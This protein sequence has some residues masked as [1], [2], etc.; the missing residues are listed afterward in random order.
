MRPD[1]KE[2]KARID[3]VEY[4]VSLGVEL[5]PVGAGGEYR[6]LCPLPGHDE[7]APSFQVNRRKGLWHCFGCGAGGDVISFVMKREGVGFQ[8][9]L[10]ILTGPAGL[11]EP[12]RSE[13]ADRGCIFCA[14]ADYWSKCLGGSPSARSYLE[15]RGIG[16]P[17]IIGRYGIGFA[18]GRTR[19]RDWLLTK[20]FALDEIESAGLV[21]RRG[22]DSFFGRVTFPLVED[23]SVVNV[24]GRSLSANY[25][26]MYLS[27]RR[28]VVFNADRVEGDSAILTESVIDALSL[29]ALGFSKAVSALSARLT[30]RQVDVIAGRFSQVVTAFDGDAAGRAGARA[31]AAALGGRGV[32]VRI[33][34][35]PDGSDVNSLVVGGATREDLEH[36]LEGYRP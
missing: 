26:H 28:D 17:E 18:P 29:V 3:I 13:G 6:G 21:N 5:K 23:G 15:R 12:V 7:A 11:D 27:A 31:T 1:A 25:K 2:I 33:A 8:E 32:D 20:G 24:Y 34:D 30:A 19:T 35:L 14:A 36:I 10:A 22:L 4:L 9:A 16:S